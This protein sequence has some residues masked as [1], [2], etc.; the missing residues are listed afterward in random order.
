[1]VYIAS[2]I[3]ETY[4]FLPKERGNKLSRTMFPLPSPRPSRTTFATHCHFVPPTHF[5]H[6]AAKLIR[7]TE[8]ERRREKYFYERRGRRRGREIERR[9]CMK[10]EKVD[11]LRIRMMARDGRMLQQAFEI[12]A[13]KAF[14]SVSLANDRVN[15]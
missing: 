10:H 3:K 14:S 15:V 2:V 1:M 9:K 5:F 12:C 11:G 13:A 4:P 8:K 7:G 6:L